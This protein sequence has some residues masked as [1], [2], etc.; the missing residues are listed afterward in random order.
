MAGVRGSCWSM[1]KDTRPVGKS[2]RVF[3]LSSPVPRYTLSFM[4]PVPVPR[5]PT[6]SYKTYKRK[7]S[8]CAI[9]VTNITQKASQ[10]LEILNPNIQ[11]HPMVTVKVTEMMSLFL[12]LTAGVKNSLKLLVY[13]C[14]IL[15]IVLLPWLDDWIVA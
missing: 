1:R 7:K 10:V 6:T 8:M 4:L 3:S 2:S 14:T 12:I 13:T 5:S 15:H 11:M 9:H